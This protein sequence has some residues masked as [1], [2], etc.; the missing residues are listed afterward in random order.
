[1]L[2]ACSSPAGEDGPGATN[3]GQAEDTIQ[4]GFLVKSLAVDFWQ[5][6]VAGAEAAADEI[7]NVEI[8]PY[9]PDSE[10]NVDQQVSQ[11]ENM[12]AQ[13]V[14]AIVIAPVAPDQLLPSLERAVEAG[15]PV[16]VLDTRVEG[17]ED[18]QSAY[19]GTDN[20]NGGVTAGEFIVEQL[21]GSGTIGLVNGTPGVPAVEDRIAGVTAATEGT[22]VEVV[23]QTAAVDCTTDNGVRAAEDLLSAHPDLDAMF[24]ACGPA[25]VGA[26]QAVKSAGIAW[27]DFVLV[28][29]DAAPEELTSVKAGEQRATIAQDQAAM[30]GDSL[31]AAVQAAKGEAIP[32]PIV[33]PGVQ[34]VT[35]DNV[36]QFIK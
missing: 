23:G 7:G 21:G 2:A 12:I 20:Y 17:F 8:L 22:G 3:S 5:Q 32:N 33:D 1:V 13:D 10:S 9:A 31:T 14:D 4:V 29:F 19:V 36:D 16:V 15:I 11:V 30:G 26:Q 35:I 25:A 34:V 24:V 27:S 28:G 18:K 6:V